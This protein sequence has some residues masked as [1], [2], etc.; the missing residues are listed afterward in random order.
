MRTL[1]FIFFLL[2]CNGCQILGE[3]YFSVKGKIHPEI[4]SEQLCRL[5]LYEEGKGTETDWREV[6]SNIDTGFVLPTKDHKYYFILDCPGYKKYKSS[7]HV[8][9]VSR[10]FGSTINLG[11]IGLDII[12]AKP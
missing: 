5:S 8:L 3:T 2:L 4:T 1:T 10:D 9:G 11:V 7:T 6:D 12:D